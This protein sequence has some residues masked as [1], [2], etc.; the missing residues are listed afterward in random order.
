MSESGCIELSEVNEVVD[1]LDLPDAAVEALL[2]AIDSRGIELK[3]RLRP[4]RARAGH[5]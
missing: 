2:D 1:A 3:R 4:R 5:L